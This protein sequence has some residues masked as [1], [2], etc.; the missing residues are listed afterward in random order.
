MLDLNSLLSG[1]LIIFILFGYLCGSI[2][3]GLIITKLNGIDDIRK[4]GSGNIGATNVLRTGKKYLA[5]MTLILDVFKSYLAIKICLMAIT[6]FDSLNVLYQDEL[7]IMSIVGVSSVVGHCFP[8]WLK[9]KG[10]KGVATGI[11]VMIAFNPI[12]GFMGI[13]IWILI[14]FI[15]KISSL[16]A[17]MMFFIYPFF[18]YT[19]NSN[20]FLVVSFSIISFIIFCKHHENILRLMKNEEPKFKK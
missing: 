4:V 2:P 19:L 8:V 13:L 7:F 16:S 20:I 5:L 14:F 11:G 12:V 6:K 10:G 17:L 1:N 18:L 3:F 15:T 9:L